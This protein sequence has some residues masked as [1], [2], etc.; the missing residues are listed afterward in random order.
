MEQH[1]FILPLI[2]EGAKEKIS[3]FIFHRNSIYNKNY[4][5]KKAFLSTEENLNNKNNLIIVLLLF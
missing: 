4:F 1:I 3:Q 2:I 5:L